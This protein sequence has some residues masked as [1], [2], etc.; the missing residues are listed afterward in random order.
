MAIL[1]KKHRDALVAL[2][3]ELAVE[4][5]RCG[6]PAHHLEAAVAEL[7]AVYGAPGAV[8]ASP[9]ALWL[10][11]G[12]RTQV[13]RLSPG[14]VDLSR[15]GR[16]SALARWRAEVAARG[17]SARR[18]R[19]KLRRV[20]RAPGLWSERTQGWAFLLAS[21]TAG[22]LIGG[23]LTD[24]VA[25]GVGGFVVRQ[26]LGVLAARP[27]WA[28][29]GDGLVAL[30]AGLFGGLCA[31]LGASPQAVSL[32]TVII[33]LPGLSLTVSVTEIAAGQWVAGGTRLLG[34]FSCLLQLAAG[35]AAGL[36]LTSGVLA[37][38][39]PLVQPVA[40]SAGLGVAALI[41]A[42]LSFAVLCGC[43][44]RESL[45][46]VLLGTLG[47]LVAS[48]VG[49]LAGTAAGAALIG[50]GAGASERSGV[51]LA[52][53][54]LVPA[55]LLLVPGC[56]GVRGMDLLLGGAVVEG[57]AVALQALGTASVIAAAALAAGALLQPA[58]YSPSI[59]AR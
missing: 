21:A 9:T 24:A 14:D 19:R 47:F 42:P 23:T 41:V 58:P 36:H 22:A 20:I 33:L 38:A 25:S 59:H 4:L 28:P 31:L 37:A 11:I 56:V 13:L 1:Q 30:T 27:Q 32:S 52:L 43:S 8:A 53:V 2:V 51:G 54:V 26:A 39:G 35:L 10:Q 45:A 17:L 12:A 44:R 48:A 7:L 16:L 18:A 50:L 40:L 55:V 34:V 6:A 49:G 57:L 15:L 3:S 5:H 29:L 46:V